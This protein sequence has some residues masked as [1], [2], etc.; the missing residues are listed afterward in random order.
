M[1]LEVVKENCASEDIEEV[2]NNMPNNRTFLSYAL[3]R[4]YSRN[5]RLIYLAVANRAPTRTILAF[6]KLTE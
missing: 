3:G 4:G 6:T 1:M 2:L 5:D